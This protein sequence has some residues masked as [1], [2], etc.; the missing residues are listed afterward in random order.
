MSPIYQHTQIGYV[1]LLS[2][3]AGLGFIAVVSAYF[4][5]PVAIAVGVVLA[6]CAVLFS[7]LTVIVRDAALHV[8]FGPG[9]I[10]R[11]IPLSR[12][13]SVRSVVTPW[14]YGW[15]IR[16]TPWGW[17]WNVSGLRAVE[18]AFDNGHTFRIGTDEPEKLASVLSRELPRHAVPVGPAPRA[19]IVIA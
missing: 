12:I 6:A 8:R 10:R 7:T 15:G 1:T 2:L 17:L 13:R 3:L 9:L 16:L 14:Y 19:R 5:H 11:T 4:P 18:L